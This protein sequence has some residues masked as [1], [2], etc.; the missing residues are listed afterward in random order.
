M[1]RGQIS[2]RDTIGWLCSP[3]E[4]IKMQKRTR[5]LR[6]QPVHI[7]TEVRLYLEAIKQPEATNEVLY[8]EWQSAELMRQYQDKA[9]PG[10]SNT[11]TKQQQEEAREKYQKFDT[12]ENRGA[13]EDAQPLVWLI[14]KRNL[15][16]KERPR[17]LLMS[18]RCHIYDW[19]VTRRMSRET[20]L[21]PTQ[22]LYRSKAG[23]P[24][25][26]SSCMRQQH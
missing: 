21:R 1:S 19:E 18:Y 13:I 23:R 10:W 11:M 5:D 2:E 26:T 9:T 3:F 4:R 24:P 16:P 8:G 20:H 15:R 12:N 7:A 14:T 22:V 6:E 25:R 17:I